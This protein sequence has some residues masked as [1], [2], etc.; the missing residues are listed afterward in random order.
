MLINP[1]GK[2]KLVER[3][4]AQCENLDRIEAARR[5][6]RGRP[7]AVTTPVDAP[8]EVTVTRPVTLAPHTGWHRMVCVDI[9]DLGMCDTP[10]GVV[11]RIEFAFELEDERREDG[12]RQVVWRKF[13]P[14]LADNSQLR[15]FLEVW[16]GYP[17]SIQEL[18]NGVP[19]AH[20]YYKRDGLVLLDVRTN[21]TT[22]NLYRQVVA[23]YP[24]PAKAAAVT[25][26]GTYI[27]KAWRAK[28]G[29]SIGNESTVGAAGRLEGAEGSDGRGDQREDGTAS[30]HGTAEA[31]GTVHGGEAER[32]AAA[33][34]D[35]TGPDGDGVGIS[36]APVLT[37]VLTERKSRMVKLNRGKR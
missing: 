9:A 35:Q 25:S 32:G 15:K 12:R 28:K 2:K 3:L 34:A 11:P 20:R 13:T 37:Y 33:A 18:Q 26:E 14:S 23:A 19:L 10:W 29:E 21:A 16:Q 4:V 24:L 5:A 1:R 36:D 30:G 31:A 6:T 27:R 22:G 17:F 7:G 8:G